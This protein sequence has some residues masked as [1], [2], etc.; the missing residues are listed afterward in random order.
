M[1][2]NPDIVGGGADIWQQSTQVGSKTR[3]I[4]YVGA[5]DIFVQNAD[6]DVL[7]P[8]QERTA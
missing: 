1:T 4:P 2:D 5:D 6:L 8:S 7:A 3:R